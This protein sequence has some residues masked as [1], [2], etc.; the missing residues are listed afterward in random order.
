MA[1]VVV[2]GPLEELDLR[3]QAWAEAIDIFAFVS[4]LAPPTALGFRQINESTILD[5]QAADAERAEERSTRTLFLT[6]SR[7][8]IRFAPDAQ[9]AQIFTSW[10]RAKLL[11]RWLLG[12]DSNQQ[13]SG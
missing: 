11:K 12:L 1:Q 2:A 7:I 5:F 4:P 3:D 13:P 8:A 6:N 10:S 9:T